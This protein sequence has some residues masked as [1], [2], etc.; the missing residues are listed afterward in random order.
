LTAEET[1]AGGF[2]ISFVFPCLNE[3]ESLPGC[4]AQAW[5]VGAALGIPAEIIVVDNGSTDESARV[6][7]DAGAR[8][9]L[10]PDPGYGSACRAGLSH[11]TGRVL[12]LVDADGSYDLSALPALLATIG[13][14]SDLVIGSRMSGSIDDGAMPWLHRKVGNP[15]LTN[16]M[17]RRF[18]VGV[19]DAQCG[20]RAITKEAYQSLSLWATGMEFASEFLIEASRRGLRIGEV[21]I[22]YRQRTGGE[23]KL[24]TVRDGLRHVRLM[25]TES[26]R[27][28]DD[29]DPAVAPTLAGS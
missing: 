24:R 2:E 16:L 22:H 11:A 13:A 28:R 21:P 15:L 25:L 7:A 1:V 9:V 26:V 19:T 18:G 8:V 3:A 6:A 17:N 20:L 4:I 5:E 23:P 14:G 29:L 10:E 12:V 27:G